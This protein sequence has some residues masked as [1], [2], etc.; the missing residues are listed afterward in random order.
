MSKLTI[1][2][3]CQAVVGTR[4]PVKEETRVVNT[5]IDDGYNIKPRSPLY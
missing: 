4:I 5:G 1:T 2:Q 3:H